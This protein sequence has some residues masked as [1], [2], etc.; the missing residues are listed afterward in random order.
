MNNCARS[1]NVSRARTLNLWMMVWIHSCSIM[2]VFVINEVYVLVRNVNPRC[3]SKF[4]DPR[5]SLET[6]VAFFVNQISSV[7]WRFEV[8][9]SF[10]L[11]G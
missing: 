9:V 8:V 2:E 7:A 5:L 3:K 1:L 6:S 11:H 4:L 10:I